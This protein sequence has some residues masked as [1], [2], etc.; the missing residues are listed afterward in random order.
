MSELQYCE[1]KEASLFELKNCGSNWEGELD[2]VTLAERKGIWHARQVQLDGN[3]L[4]N[5]D[6]PRG[7]NGR[8]APGSAAG[9]PLPPKSAVSGT[10]S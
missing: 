7:S 2:P 6:G 10:D 5:R 9:L 3:T 8:G 4:M 1:E